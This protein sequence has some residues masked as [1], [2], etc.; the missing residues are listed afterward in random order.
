MEN[1]S[2]S[3]IIGSSNAPY[4]NSLARECGMAA[5]FFAEGHPSLPNYIAMTSG[6]TQGIDD[7][8]SPLE[9]PLSVPSIFEALGGGWRS[10]EE[11][12]PSN[13]YLSDSGLYVVHH[14]PAAY[15]TNIRT[16][17]SSQD[18]PLAS[19]PDLSAPFTFIT[20]NL[21][22]DM[23]SCSTADGDKWLSTFIPRLLG[24]DQY[25]SGTTAIF[26]T[27]DESDS[28]SASNH[29]ATLVISP[30]TQPGTV[31]DTLFNHYSML[32][33]TESMLGIP[34]IASSCTA[35]SMRAA[36]NL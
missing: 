7:D 28:S 24:S 3:D 4:I 29:I 22:N 20:P 35:T 30:S 8:G 11:S 6:S 31:S 14:N 36:F 16:A 2:Y 5:N 9:H 23:H 19:V 15:Y 18:V 10:L 27:W 26:L 21:C 13:C 34:C 32:Q 25:N 33:T 12:M 1:S 17:C